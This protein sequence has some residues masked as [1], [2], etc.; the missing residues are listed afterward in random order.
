MQNFS[1]PRLV[2]FPR[3][4]NSVFTSTIHKKQMDS[5]FQI[6]QNEPSIFFYNTVYHNYFKQISTLLLF[7]NMTNAAILNTYI[8]KSADLYQDNLD[9]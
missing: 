5:T 3:L 6:F 7:T 4:K 2:D 9:I 1:S 8:F